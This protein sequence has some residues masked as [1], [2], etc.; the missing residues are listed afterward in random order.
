MA[1]EL[2]GQ[3]AAAKSFLSQVG[4]GSDSYKEILE[5]Q[6]TMALAVMAP[7]GFVSADDSARL[8]MAISQMPFGKRAMAK[9]LGRVTEL[10]TSSAQA[11][12]ANAAAGA[13][14]MESS[15]TPMQ[16]FTP[17]A[18]YLAKKQWDSILDER[19]DFMGRVAV[20]LQACRALG[21]RTLHEP[22]IQM[23]T[24]IALM[25]DGFE[26]AMRLCPM[27]QWGYFKRAKLY[28]KKLMPWTL[29]KQWAKSEPSF[30]THLPEVPHDLARDHP[31]WYSRAYGGGGEAPV[32]CPLDRTTLMVLCDAVPMRESKARIKSQV[33]ATQS[34]I[35]MAFQL[36]DRAMTMH[37]ADRQDARGGLACRQY[38]PSLPTAPAKD[39][40]IPLGD[41]EP[42][43]SPKHAQP[44]THSVQEA[45][46]QIYKQL[47]GKPSSA[48]KAKPTSDDESG[49]DGSECKSGDCDDDSAEQ[50]AAP[51]PM[52]G[53]RKAAGGGHPKAKAKKNAK[54]E[55]PTV[56]SK[57]APRP[58]Y[59]VE[60]SRSQ[61]LCRTGTP[62]PGQSM[63]IK[64]SDHGGSSDK[65]IAV[66]E[67]WVAKQLKKLGK[68]A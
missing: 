9:L 27:A 43:P 57:K 22:T 34:P 50:D 55:G 24:C 42:A 11:L 15:R 58:S 31:E 64:F 21:L 38:S 28:A 14:L 19:A 53:K 20:V 5:A 12:A 68:G 66:A 61:V 60:W 40:P 35:D 62:G 47:G 30:V 16:D 48:S 44:S 17:I 63:A 1:A 46:D 18:V 45:R 54:K 7:R 10:A 65:A 49:D 25:V 4:K 32:A 13:E 36:A 6:S 67:K 41:V 52:K 29:C 56:M 39:G 59:S 33:Q 26:W 2:A 37:R 23:A 51:P 8:V 3:L